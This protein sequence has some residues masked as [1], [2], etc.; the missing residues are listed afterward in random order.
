MPWWWSS[1]Q[2]EQQQRPSLPVAKATTVVAQAQ[3]VVQATVVATTP[4]AQAATPQSAPSREPPRER[5]PDMPTPL[6]L[7]DL[8]I[9]TLQYMNDNTAATDDWISDLRHVKD[10]AKRAQE[11]RER[12]SKLASDLVDK[13]A[14]FNDLMS[15]YTSTLQALE[16]RRAAVRELDE[17]RNAML[18]LRA[19]YKMADTLEERAAVADE[20]AEETLADALDAAPMDAAALTEFR[21]R[22]V[23]QKTD[24]HWR[25]AM[26]ES[27]LSS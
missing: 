2:E 25:L 4:N 20:Q 15:N 12:N 10:V 24:K 19:P 5:V 22:F 23:Q 3:P 9:T 17:Q 1:Q 16:A 27:L 18:L 7:A 6:P 8:S 26:K 21:Q 13:E 14:V 11:A